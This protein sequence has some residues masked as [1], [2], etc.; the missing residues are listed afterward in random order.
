M[1]TTKRAMSI[2]LIGTAFLAAAA[3]SAA[4]SEEGIFTK[5]YQRSLQSI[6]MMDMMDGNKDHMVTKD[7]FMAYQ[8]RM[9]DMMDRNKDGMID[10]KEWQAKLGGIGGK[11]TN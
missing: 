9:F 8:T 1:R 5:E 7:E 3:M 6:K 10:P 11:G 2:K 4:A